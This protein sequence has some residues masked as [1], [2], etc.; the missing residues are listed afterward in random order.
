MDRLH[1]GDSRLGSESSKYDHYRIKLENTTRCNHLKLW[2]K[3]RVHS[4][5]L[6]PHLEIIIP[7]F[8]TLVGVCPDS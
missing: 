4:C 7:V 5:A 3:I 2:V 6:K 1:L 8:I